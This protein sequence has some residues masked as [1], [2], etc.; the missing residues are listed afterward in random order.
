[1]LLTHNY[2]ALLIRSVCLCDSSNQEEMLGSI[3]KKRLQFEDSTKLQEIQSL[4]SIVNKIKF[5]IVM[6][7]VYSL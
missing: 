1:M 7:K 3:Q 2:K 6:V 4:V 5:M